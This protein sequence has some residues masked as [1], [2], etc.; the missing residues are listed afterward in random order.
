MRI[1]RD[2]HNK[3]EVVTLEQAQAL[4]ACGAEVQEPPSRL[5]RLLACWPA[6][7]ILIGAAA[8]L[9]WTAALVWFVIGLFI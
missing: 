6:A 9:A 2:I 8:S 1:D 4:G 7:G 5:R 3:A